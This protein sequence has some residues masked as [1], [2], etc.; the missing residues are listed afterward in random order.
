MQ[1]FGN[2]AIVFPDKIFN[3]YPALIHTLFTC[4]FSDDFKLLFTALDTF[5]NL[6]KFS[7]G[8]RAL[9]SLDGDQCLKVL[10]HIAKAIPSYP[11]ELKVEALNCFEGVFFVDEVGAQNNQIN[12]ICQKW[13]SVVFGTDLMALLAFCQI[14]FEDIAMAAFKVL[15]SLAGHDFGQRAVAAT[16]ETMELSEVSLFMFRLLLA[17]QVDSL[18]F[19]STA[20]PK[21][22]ST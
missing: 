11:S 3:A 15:R 18:N 1:F 10:Q 14:P 21:F 5:G 4:I 16:G 22:L 20:T 19:F 2:V 12:Y 6:A 17:S 7:D 8:K 13:F 9:D